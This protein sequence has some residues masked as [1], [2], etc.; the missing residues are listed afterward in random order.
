M[1]YK[2]EADKYK[3]LNNK[4]DLIHLIVRY[5]EPTGTKYKKKDFKHLNIRQLQAIWSNI[6]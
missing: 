6:L 3:S 4:S 5:I 2:C 1:Q